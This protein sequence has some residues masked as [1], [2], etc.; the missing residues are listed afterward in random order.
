M[1]E[2]VFIKN[3]PNRGF[4]EQAKQVLTGNGINCI[5]KSPDVGILGTS[6]SSLLIGVNL[7]VEKRHQERA[8][9]L[10]DAIFDGI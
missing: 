10:L 1:D 2:I 4:A 7:Y 3:F 9:E 8:Y 5:L 6:S